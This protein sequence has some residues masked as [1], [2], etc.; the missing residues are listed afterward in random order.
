ML[1]VVEGAGK[2]YRDHRSRGAVLLTA[3]ASALC[4][5]ACPPMQD[6]HGTSSGTT[7][8]P[9]TLAGRVTEF[10]RVGDTVWLPAAGSSASVRQL[11]IHL[12]ETGFDGAPRFL[13]TEPEGSMALI[14]A[15]GWVPADARCQ[16]LGL[17][18]APR[19]MFGDFE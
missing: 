8:E 10:V 2:D 11:L 15:E 18:E 19:V 7:P 6:R 16:R 3:L 14:W 17:G 5:S 12:E 1:A 9:E 4:S 13:G